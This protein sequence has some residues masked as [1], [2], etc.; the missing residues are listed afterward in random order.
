MVKKLCQPEFNQFSESNCAD[1]EFTYFWD[2]LKEVRHAM[3]HCKGKTT[4]VK[5]YSKPQHIILANNYFNVTTIN[6]DSLIISIDF[7]GLNRIT[8]L[9]SEFAYQIY[10]ILCMKDGLDYKSIFK[11]K[12]L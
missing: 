4:K 1:V 7:V 11:K 10:K 3:T 2:F 5:I 8:Q 6:D 12:Q 9:I